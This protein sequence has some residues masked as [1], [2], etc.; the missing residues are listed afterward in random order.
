MTPHKS[1][2]ASLRIGLAVVACGLALGTAS[3]LAVAN[4]L[5]DMVR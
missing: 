5:Y 4:A 1:P 2:P 3:A